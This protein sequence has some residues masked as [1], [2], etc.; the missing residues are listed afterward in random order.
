MQ[1]AHE[2]F[3]ALEFTKRTKDTITRVR[4]QVDRA[5]LEPS[6]DD[7]GT[8]HAHLLA[9]IGGDAEI[10]AIWAAITEGAGRSFVSSSP[11][12]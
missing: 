3:G 11:F 10:G 2:R 5:V 6:R 9:M 4:V 12:R 8:T 7:R 1:N